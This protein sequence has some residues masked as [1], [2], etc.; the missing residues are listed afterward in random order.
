MHRARSS[1]CSSSS[2]TVDPNHVSP[3]PQIFCSL[4]QTSHRALVR[5]SRSLCTSGRALKHS[6]KYV[7]V[8]RDR[9][10]LARSATTSREGFRPHLL[11]FASFDRLLSRLTPAT[12]PWDDSQADRL[13]FCGYCSPHPILER[14]EEPLA[15]AIDA[16][17]AIPGQKKRINWS[18]IALGGIMNMF[19]VR[20]TIHALDSLTLSQ[21][22]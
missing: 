20:N 13:L 12:K 18:N 22:E 21:L 7:Q 2:L 16:G 4:S 5:P 3:L 14:N 10:A 15:M 17:P 19:E 8:Y 9:F 11:S 6:K 1:S